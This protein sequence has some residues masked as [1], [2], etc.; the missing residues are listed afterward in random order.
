MSRTMGWGLIVLSL[1]V[2]G[3]GRPA[4][5][6]SAYFGWGFQCTNC[7]KGVTEAGL[8][9]EFTSPPEIIGVDAG[10]PA[11]RA[12]IKVGDV[13][14]TVDGETLTKK[15][16]S[17][18]LFKARPGRTLRIGFRR[19]TLRQETMIRVGSQADAE[20]LGLLSDRSEGKASRPLGAS[21]D[22]P[23]RFSGNLDQ[24]SIE[25][26]GSPNVHVVM[27]L[28]ESWMDIVSNDIRVKIRRTAD[29]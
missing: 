15:S 7:L 9:M 27:P 12:G 19:G 4:A 22:A 17:D 6:D 8:R 21:A 23:I 10:G 13:I 5:A 16:G 26:R 25:V 3:G 11:A 14:L 2:L 28:D 24:F 1:S 18:R 20:K 29:K